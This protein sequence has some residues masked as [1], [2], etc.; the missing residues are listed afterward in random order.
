[1]NGESGCCSMTDNLGFGQ[2]TT[3]CTGPIFTHLFSGHWVSSHNLS[4]VFGSHHSNFQRSDNGW[5]VCK[6]RTQDPENFDD[7]DKSLVSAWCL[8]YLFYGLC[9][10]DPTVCPE[11][12]DSS[13]II[14]NDWKAAAE[15][16]AAWAG[17]RHMRLK[18]R[19]NPSLLWTNDQ[20][21]KK[22]KEKPKER[23]TLRPYQPSVHNI[24]KHPRLSVSD[25]WLVLGLQ[26][27]DKWYTES[28][29]VILLV[30]VF[31]T[32]ELNDEQ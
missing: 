28:L 4:L 16:R 22:E 14:R 8:V 25:Q 3:G 29:S 32:L 2:Q 13:I 17:I 19:E 15:D 26:L 1:M 18:V 24:S 31:L 9:L 30:K 21:S 23:K 10:W 27:N 12:Q 11:G 7:E 6:V 20:I 5:S